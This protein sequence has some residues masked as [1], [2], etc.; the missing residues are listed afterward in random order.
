MRS[1]LHGQPC[2]TVWSN[3]AAPRMWWI[4]VP[5]DLESHCPRWA[6]VWAF[7]PQP[8][9][10]FSHSYHPSCLHYGLSVPSQY[11]YHRAD[12]V[13]LDF[14]VPQLPGRAQAGLAHR[15]KP[16]KRTK[17]SMDARTQTTPRAPQVSANA[18]IWPGQMGK[19]HLH[20][21]DIPGQVC[22]TWWARPCLRT[23]H[24]KW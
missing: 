9:Y 22:S 21:M 8:Q 11:R 5:M 1:P 13:D 18:S 10:F 15:N 12:S 20:R 3:D 6:A 14:V 23:G 2:G 19:M 16:V 7:C 17:S 24:P 4:I